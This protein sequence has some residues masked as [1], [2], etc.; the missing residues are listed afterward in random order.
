MGLF[1]FACS[2]SVSPA[3]YKKN[4]LFWDSTSG[5]TYV[6]WAAWFDSGYK[7]FRQSRRPVDFS[8]CGALPDHDVLAVGHGTVCSQRV[9]KLDV[10]S[11]PL[12]TSVYVLTATCVIKLEI[13][14][15]SGGYGTVSGMD[16]GR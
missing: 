15:R 11:L 12:D 4:E 2:V 13:G 3:E 14:V 1:F 6:F 5:T 16:T 10:A 7:C 8:T 9:L